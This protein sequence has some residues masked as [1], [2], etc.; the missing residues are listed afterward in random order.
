MQHECGSHLLPQ[1]SLITVDPATQCRRRLMG[2]AH[3]AT[4]MVCSHYSSEYTWGAGNTP[5]AHA[6]AYTGRQVCL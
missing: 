1:C 2:R 5:S 3:K 4:D 6:R